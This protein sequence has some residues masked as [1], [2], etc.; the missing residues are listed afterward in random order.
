MSL[1]VS[2]SEKV[3][4]YK[5]YS[6]IFII[7]LFIAISSSSF[8]SILY[9]IIPIYFMTFFAS[10]A[11]SYFILPSRASAIPNASFLLFVS[12]FYSSSLMLYSVLTN[13]ISAINSILLYLY[14]PLAK[15]LKLII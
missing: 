11:S 14:D 1:F 6:N 13:K 2:Y 9:F 3:V 7:V 4:E 5:G 8:R 10:K 12:A 15:N